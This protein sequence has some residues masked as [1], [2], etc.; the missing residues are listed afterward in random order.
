MEE[1]RRLFLNIF[2]VPTSN[3]H[4]QGGVTRLY[5]DAG[6][7]FGAWRVER[8]HLTQCNEDIELQW[9]K[10]G[11]YPFPYEQVVIHL[12]GG[13]SRLA[14]VNGEKIPFREGRVTTGVFDHMQLKV[15]L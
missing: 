12:H 8:F 13:Q 2:A 5:S 3:Q 14:W 9:K 7:G 1:G 11:D 15:D 10:Q 6:D 4:Q